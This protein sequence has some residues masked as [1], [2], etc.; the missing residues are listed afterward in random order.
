MIETV[1][2]VTAVQTM[3]FEVFGSILDRRGNRGHSGARQN[4]YR[5]AGDDNWIAVTIRTDDEWDAFVA[6]MGDQE[7]DPEQWFGTQEASSVVDRLADSGNSCRRGGFAVPG[8][9]EPSAVAPRLL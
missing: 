5:C 7:A 2:N 9:G 6:L 3:E 1:L 8:D 4:L